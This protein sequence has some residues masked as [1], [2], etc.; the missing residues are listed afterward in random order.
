MDCLAVVFQFQRYD[1]RT[2]RK[3]DSKHN[4]IWIWMKADR[5]TLY[6]NSLYF[7]QQTDTRRG[8]NINVHI[9]AASGRCPNMRRFNS[10]CLFTCP[11]AVERVYIFQGKEFE[12]GAWYG[13]WLR[14]D[15]TSEPCYTPRPHMAVV[16]AHWRMEIAVT[17]KSSLRA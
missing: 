2:D 11:V 5:G 7:H 14:G 1:R 10:R 13:A 17:V 9:N 16:C 4:N 3:M 6:L 15:G 12:G 8:V